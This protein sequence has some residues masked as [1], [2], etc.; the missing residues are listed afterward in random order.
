V[1]PCVWGVPSGGAANA[2][3]PRASASSTRANCGRATGA[4]HSVSVCGARML[5]RMEDGP[6]V[7][8]VP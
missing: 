5:P 8:A 3:R 4:A 1:H 2:R 7:T 6:T